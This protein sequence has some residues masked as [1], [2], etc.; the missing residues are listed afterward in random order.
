MPPTVASSWAAWPR[1]ARPWSGKAPSSAELANGGTLAF[2]GDRLLISIGDLQDPDAVDD[3]DALN[4]KILSLDPMGSP[5]QEPTFVSGG[6]NN[7][8]AMTVVA[9]DIWLVD[10]APGSQPERIVRI[11]PSGEESV[12]EL[13]GERAPSSLDV[14]PD[15]D[16]VLCGF[17]SEVVERIPVPD[18][19]VVAPTEELGPPCSTGVAVL[20]D[21]SIVTTTVDAIWR[22]PR[23]Q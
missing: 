22:D 21:G 13:T 15:G 1:T 17:V 18:T 3:P 16:L 14:L 8:F 4:G 9:G 11:A 19:G 5:D 6:W 2:R 7:P 23:H 10:N 12:L 20:A